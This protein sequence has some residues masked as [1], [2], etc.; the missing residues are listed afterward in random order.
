[1]EIK[2]MTDGLAITVLAGSECAWLREELKEKIES[3]AILYFDVDET[4]DV[5]EKAG[6]TREELT[7]PL[8]IVSRDGEAE[9]SS[10]VISQV[11]KSVIVHCENTVIPLV[12]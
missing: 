2:T 8:A 3:G 5:L 12:D 10:C 6:L 4:P 11:G 1:M 9:G 7:E